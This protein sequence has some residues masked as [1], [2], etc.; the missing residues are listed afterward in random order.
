ME[1]VDRYID[2]DN[3]AIRLLC[4]G[5]PLARINYA[6]PDRHQCPEHLIKIICRYFYT[7]H[8]G[9]LLPIFNLRVFIV[10]VTN[11]FVCLKSF[12]YLKNKEK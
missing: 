3:T 2:A 11:Y 5:D 10:R 6:V 8:A 9:F 12:S 1:K 4:V 7:S